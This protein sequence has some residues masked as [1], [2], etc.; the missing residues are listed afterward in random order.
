M[1]GPALVAQGGLG[2]R[3]VVDQRQKAGQ[4]YGFLAFTLSHSSS[5][6]CELRIE[7]APVYFVP[8]SDPN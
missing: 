2:E 5:L 4:R 7:K 1:S 3:P 8:P 6:A